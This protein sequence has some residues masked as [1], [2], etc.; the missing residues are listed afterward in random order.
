MG[1][2]W[3][4]EEKEVSNFY[5]VIEFDGLGFNLLVIDKGVIGVVEVF[6]SEGVVVK[7]EVGVLLVD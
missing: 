6:E 4:E 3:F 2:E 7:G 5:L 1:V